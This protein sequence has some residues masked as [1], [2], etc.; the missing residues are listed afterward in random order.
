MLRKDRTPPTR[1]LNATAKTSAS[2]G[3]NESS[4]DFGMKIETTN[5]PSINKTA[6]ETPSLIT[7]MRSWRSEIST[8]RLIGRTPQTPR[9]TRPRPR[10]AWHC[11]STTQ[12]HPTARAVRGYRGRV[13]GQPFCSASF[14]RLITTRARRVP[15]QRRLVMI[16]GALAFALFNTKKEYQNA[17]E[18]PR[19]IMKIAAKFF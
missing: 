8:E 17:S 11:P 10:P 13:D 2:T 18:A 16:A 19:D 4:D 1:M 15:C 14:R 6:I 9:Q 7:P 3:T 12:T 5:V